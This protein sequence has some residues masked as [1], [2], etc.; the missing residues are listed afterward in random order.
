MLNISNEW[1]SEKIL[2]SEIPNA[3]RSRLLEL[4]RVLV[5]LGHI[6]PSDCKRESRQHVDD[7]ALCRASCRYSELDRVARIRLRKA[8]TVSTALI[9]RIHPMIAKI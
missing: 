8:N 7:E 6:A 5:R 4:A 1:E 2:R 3:I 9:N